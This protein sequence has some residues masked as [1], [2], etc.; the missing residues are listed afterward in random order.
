MRQ[1]NYYYDDVIN[2]A[3]KA[4]DDHIP[5]NSNQ[6]LRRRKSIFVKKKIAKAKIYLKF[7][8]NYNLKQI[9]NNINI[10]KIYKFIKF[11]TLNNNKQ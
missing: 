2:A 1:C 4:K 5:M 10:V 11:S 7:S 8:I 6:I 9:I 3:D